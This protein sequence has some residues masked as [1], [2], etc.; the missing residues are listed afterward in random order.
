MSKVVK[1]AGGRDGGQWRSRTLARN[2][3]GGDDAR[4]PNPARRYPAETVALLLQQP[5]GRMSAPTSPESEVCRENRTI[6]FQGEGQINAIPQRQ[7]VLHRQ[8]E[9]AGK[10]RARVE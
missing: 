6:V 4:A 3:L 2:G 10:L 8:I 7:L 5:D 1:W 9:R